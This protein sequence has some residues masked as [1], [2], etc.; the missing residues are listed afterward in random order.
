MK[1][2]HLIFSMACLLAACSQD[3]ARQEEPAMVLQVSTEMPTT[4]GVI[5]GT[6]FAKGD[7]IAVA[8]EKQNGNLYEENRYY[9]FYEYDGTDWKNSSSWRG[10]LMLTSEEGVVYACY[11]PQDSNWIKDGCWVSVSPLSGEQSEYLYGKS[12]ENVSCK[13]PK[14]RLRFQFA[15]ARLTFQIVM[16]GVSTSAQVLSS[17]KL[18]TVPVRGMMDV[19]T[20]NITSTQQDYGAVT[21][22]VNKTLGVDA[23]TLVDVLVIPTPTNSYTK[24]TLTINSIDYDINIPVTTWEKGKQYTYPVTLNITENQ[25]SSKE[26]PGEKVYMGFNGDNGKPLYWSS[27]NLGATKIDDYGGYYAWGEKVNKSNYTWANYAHC[28]GTSN[29][30]HSIG[31]EI[32]GTQ[33]D[34]ARQLWGSNWRIPSRSELKSL[35]D[36]SNTTWITINGITGVRFTSKKNN[37]NIFLPAAGYYSSTG[38]NSI[39]EIANYAS[40]SIYIHENSK[41][42]VWEMWIQTEKYPTP[43]FAVGIVVNGRSIRPVTE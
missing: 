5:T 13:N 35:I 41:D 33:Y 38:N 12:T 28:D 43:T 1:A 22:S 9:D 27:W 40:S 25:Q 14:A 18:A 17:V 24:L 10:G 15:L 19:K 34:A 30:Y 4:R 31:N 23:A 36:N 8:V 7:N 39:G 21:L 37:N 2:K 16:G 20:G 32:G 3:E 42:N 29:T 6:S 11:P 26:T